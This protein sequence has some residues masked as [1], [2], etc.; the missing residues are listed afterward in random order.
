MDVWIIFS[1][2]GNI[3]VHAGGDVKS[4]T[5]NT[6]MSHILIVHPVL[7]FFYVSLYINIFYS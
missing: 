5:K 6:K 2:I 3:I 1:G 4:K 7:I